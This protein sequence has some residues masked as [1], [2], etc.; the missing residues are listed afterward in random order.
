MADLVKPVA[1]VAP[2]PAPAPGQV[3]VKPAAPAAAS[4]QPQ[5]VPPTVN[6]QEPA[7]PL[8]T[9]K[10]GTPEA[11]RDPHRGHGGTYHIDPV[12][13]ARVRDK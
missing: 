8:P 10:D 13:G 6:L 2:K 4:A 11:H 7:K 9:F 1:P 12:T 5:T 3:A